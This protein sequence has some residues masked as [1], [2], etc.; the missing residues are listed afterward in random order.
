MS[1]QQFVNAVQRD[2]LAP[3]PGR[4]AQYQ[5]A[6]RPRAGSLPYDQAPESARRSGVLI[7]FYPD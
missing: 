2:L 3:L 1:M 5:M 7:L 6:P 4:V